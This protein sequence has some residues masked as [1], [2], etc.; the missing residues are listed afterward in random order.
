MVY[1]GLITLDGLAKL[2]KDVLERK[3]GSGKNAEKG[4]LG[5]CEHYPDKTEMWAEKAVAEM[6]QKLGY[7]LEGLG[8]LEF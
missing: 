5:A 1:T 2:G 6:G 3:L 7:G 8:Y 4:V